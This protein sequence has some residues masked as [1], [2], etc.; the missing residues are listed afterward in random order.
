M[1]AARRPQSA[2]D[3]P[4]RPTPP[5]GQAGTEYFDSEV[6]GREDGELRMESGQR[7]RTA[8]RAFLYSLSSPS[9][10]VPLI[11]RTVGEEAGL[12]EPLSLDGSVAVQDIDVD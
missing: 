4:S 5:P 7:L 6:G 9:S 10:P 8:F 11:A 1:A 2:T 12:V 3:R